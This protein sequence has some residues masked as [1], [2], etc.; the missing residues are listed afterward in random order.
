M[1]KVSPLT[2]VRLALVFLAPWRAASP[3]LAVTINDRDGPLR[4]EPF[5]IIGDSMNVAQCK[6]ARAGLG[7]T[8]DDL[9]SLAGLSRRSV[10]RFENGE[11]LK[12]DSIEAM[13]RALVGAGASFVDMSGKVGVL[14]KP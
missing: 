3:L 12:P 9:A 4:Q 7:L 11:T 2:S 8:V 6:M 13:A 1:S 14:I 10:I 5:C